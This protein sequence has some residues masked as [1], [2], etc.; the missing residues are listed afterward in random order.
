MNNRPDQTFTFRSG[1]CGRGHANSYCGSTP[2]F[3]SIVFA[4]PIENE[5]AAERQ[6]KTFRTQSVGTSIESPTHGILKPDSTAAQNR[7]E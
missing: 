4:D 7:A 1:R 2:C 3:P 5:E 6:E